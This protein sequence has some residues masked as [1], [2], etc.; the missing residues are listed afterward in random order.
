M[1]RIPPRHRLVL[2]EDGSA[3]LH[4]E[5]FDETCHSLAGAREETRLHYLKG[6]EVEELLI[7][8]Q[9][10][11]ILEVGF[12]TGLGWNESLALAEA[13]P[14]RLEFVSLELDEDLV[15][16][17]APEAQRH[18]RQGQIWYR[19]DRGHHRLNVLVGDART[20]MPAWTE[21]PRFHAFY[22]DAFSPKKNPTLWTVEWFHLLGSLAEPGARLS[23]YSASVS[24]R[25]AMVEAGWGVTPGERFGQKR[26]STRAQ[27]GAP[28]DAGILEQLARSPSV[29]LR[30]Q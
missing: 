16:W 30:D 29:A 15:R 28:S 4:S 11:K 25:K 26:A 2:T 9:T 6:C 3:S 5:R 7:S 13:Y 14:S 19:L 10:V 21:A 27:W 1:S 18:E 8:R 20:T 22:Q 23:T 24:V 17:A 12:G